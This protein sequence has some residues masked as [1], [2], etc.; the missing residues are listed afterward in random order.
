MKVYNE[1]VIELDTELEFLLEEYRL[2]RNFNASE[3]LD[4]KIDKIVDYFK[5]SNLN[6]AV[7]ALS[8]GID[9]SI[10]YAIMQKASQRNPE[11]ISK[12]YGVSLPALS[13]VGATHQEDTLKRVSELC[14]NYGD[15]PFIYEG[16]NT[17]VDTATSNLE[18]MLNTQNSDWVKGQLVSYMRTPILYNICSILTDNN[19]PAIIIGTSNLSEG[20]YLGYIGKAS[21]GV[22]DVQIIS[23]LFKS[24]VYE[25]AR[26]LNMPKSIMHTI[27]TGDMYDGRSDEEVFGATYDFVEL[28]HL[29]T[30]NH[31]LQETIDNIMNNSLSKESRDLL[32]EGTRRI[33][34]VHSY[35]AHKYLYDMPCVYINIMETD[36]PGGWSLKNWN[37]HQ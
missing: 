22:T 12:I 3:W 37:P 2:K 4:S 33:D 16:L 10:V 9:S 20:A 18:K 8:G 26:L 5:V 31:T 13:H 21:D 17:L 32:A 34:K 23:D 25:V 28:H 36:M 29:L 15:K 14:E 35:N 27:P 7:V 6:T 1:S 19:Q 30:M 11:V 24:E